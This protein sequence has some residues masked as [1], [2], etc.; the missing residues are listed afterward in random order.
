MYPSLVA[1]AFR[2]EVFDV[3]NMGLARLTISWGNT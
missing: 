1:Q 3:S 2:P